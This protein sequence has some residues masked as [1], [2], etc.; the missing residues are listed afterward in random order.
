MNQR[1][2][3]FQKPFHG[4]HVGDPAAGDKPDAPNPGPN[5]LF[6]KIHRMGGQDAVF[7]PDGGAE[8]SVILLLDQDGTI[9]FFQDGELF[10]PA[11]IDFVAQPKVAQGR[12]ANADEIISIKARTSGGNASR[13]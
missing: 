8:I 1:P 5:R 3:I 13:I 12:V 7:F 6:G 4:V 11:H 2:D 10:V 9:E